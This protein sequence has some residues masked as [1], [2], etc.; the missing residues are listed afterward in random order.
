[1]KLFELFAELS[2]DTNKFNKGV[3]AASKQGTSLADKLS[4][5]F[6]SVSA[7]TVAMGHALYD[8]S[9]TAAKAVF[10]L[11]KAAVTGYAQTEQL[12]GG[13]QTMFGASADA[14]I[15]NAQMAYKT[16]GM[17]A[18]AYMETV[19]SFSASLL[20]SLGG[21]TQKAASYADMAVQDMAD[22]ANKF[23]TDMASIQNAYQG[24]AKQNYTIELMSAA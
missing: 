15:R 17:D 16:A 22:N 9:K 6:Q 20:K 1:M 8:V 5:G 11:G 21:D 19:T 7:K 4:G 14:V 24:F 2:L 3:S 13:V 10:G 12:I 23:G 18:N